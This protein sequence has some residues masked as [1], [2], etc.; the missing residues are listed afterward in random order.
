MSSRA[1][2]PTFGDP[3]LQQEIMRLRRV[4]NFSNLWYLACE[5]V[6]LAV[7][8]GGAVGFAECRE[9]LG[10][11]WSWNVPVFAMA[12]IV[13][14]GIQHRLAGL[15]HEASHY[16]FM[17]DRYLN[18]LVPDVF[19]MFPLLTSVHFYRLFHMA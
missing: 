11:A 17:K 15:G 14:G 7:V 19:C 2:R 8:I 4:D 18:D 1:E 16:T 5:Y 6:S 10:L 13:V 3:R 9:S 12:I